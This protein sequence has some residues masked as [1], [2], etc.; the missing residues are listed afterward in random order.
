[1]PS[2]KRRLAEGGGSARPGRQARGTARARGI[3]GRNAREPRLPALK[4]G[5]PMQRPGCSRRVVR[6]GAM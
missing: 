6:A 2:L 4:P 5:G 1:M 3:R